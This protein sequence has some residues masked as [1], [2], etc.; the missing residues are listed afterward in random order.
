[1]NLSVDTYEMCL[2]QWCWL[3]KGLKKFF[4]NHKH[5][6]IIKVNCYLQSDQNDLDRIL[7]VGTVFKLEKGS[8]V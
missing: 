7:F 4:Y 8:G 5:F 6:I 1:M 2:A 3:P